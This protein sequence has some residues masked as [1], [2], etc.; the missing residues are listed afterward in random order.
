LENKKVSKQVIA[1]FEST[2]LAQHHFH[3]KQLR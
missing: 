1:N 3:K 2:A